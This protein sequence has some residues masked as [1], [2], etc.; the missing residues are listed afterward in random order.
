MILQLRGN[1]PGGAG[2]V[3]GFHKGKNNFTG[4]IV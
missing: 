3:G 2:L 4:K 1:I